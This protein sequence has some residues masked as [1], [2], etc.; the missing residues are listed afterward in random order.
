M[1]EQT[2]PP[3]R[4]YLAR[5]IYAWICDNDFTPYIL[6][7]TNYQGVFVPKQFIKD[8][9]IVLNIAPHAVQNFIMDNNVI[10]FKAR[11]AGVAQE[12]YVPMMALVGIYSRENGHGLFFDPEEYQDAEGLYAKPDEEQQTDDSPAK[13]KPSLRILD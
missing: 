13:K 6:V 1:S 9:Q 8:G 4:P 3:T 12:V 10:S 11:F 2:L 5:A 7:D